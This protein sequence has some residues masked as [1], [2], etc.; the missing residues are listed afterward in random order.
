MGNHSSKNITQPLK[1]E[2]QHKK[3]LKRESEKSLSTYK[4]HCVF[5]FLS[6]HACTMAMFHGGFPHELLREIIEKM[7]FC[8][9][10]S[11][12]IGRWINKA[13]YDG[14]VHCSEEQF[15][16][17]WEDIQNE[18]IDGNIKILEPFVVQNYCLHLSSGGY[19]EHSKFGFLYL[20]YIESNKI[21]TSTEVKLLFNSLHSGMRGDIKT[22]WD[23]F[24]VD[25]SSNPFIFKDRQR[26]DGRY[27]QGVVLLISDNCVIF[28]PSI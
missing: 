1:P 25:G 12:A 7:Y 26:G 8:R 11:F 5:S 13:T 15:L 20:S 17:Y 28:H 18:Y 9:K 16:E 19:V 23:R 6:M 27:P 22:T 24:P 2:T 14:Y 10:I 21:D 4:D 3:R